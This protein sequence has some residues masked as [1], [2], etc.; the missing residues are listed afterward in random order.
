[1]VIYD[2]TCSFFLNK[3]SPSQ[4]AASSRVGVPILRCFNFCMGLHKS[5]EGRPEV[6]GIFYDLTNAFGSVCVPLILQNV[7]KLLR[8]QKIYAK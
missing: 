7:E 1:V 2:Q 5:M 8:L 4:H 3:W 6:L